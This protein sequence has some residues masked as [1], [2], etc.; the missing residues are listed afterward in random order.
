MMVA[1]RYGVTNGELG[2]AK[3]DL[4]DSVWGA[5]CEF[6]SYVACGWDETCWEYLGIRG[7]L[8]DML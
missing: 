1:G 6:F 7:Y 5:F 2:L 4:A 8:P 3:G